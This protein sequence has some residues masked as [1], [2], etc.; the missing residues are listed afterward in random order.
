MRPEGQPI[1]EI[2]WKAV[3]NSTPLYFFRHS[4]LCLPEGVLELQQ[5]SM[6]LPRFKR[7]EEGGRE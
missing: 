1:H 7:L 5:T 2:R 4:L 3:A 6:P